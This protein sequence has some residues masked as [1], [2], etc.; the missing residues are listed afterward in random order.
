M[1]LE[2][3]SSSIMLEIGHVNVLKS[4]RLGEKEM[5]P[6][7]VSW[8]SIGGVSPDLASAFGDTI[9]IASRLAKSM[10]NFIQVDSLDKII[11]VIADGFSVRQQRSGVVEIHVPQGTIVY[12]PANEIIDFYEV[13]NS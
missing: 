7:T 12:A 9:A 10:D 4:R 6:T 8:S 5:R 2:I 3:T 11:V 13:V 1:R